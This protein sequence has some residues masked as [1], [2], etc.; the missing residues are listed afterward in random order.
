M[1]GK[2]QSISNDDWLAAFPLIK[3]IVPEHEIIKLEA[4]TIKDIKE[5][6]AGKKAAY[7]WSGGK[8]SIVL[9]ALCRKAGIHDCLLAV[10]NLEYPVF[11]DWLIA[12]QP[13][14]LEIINTGQDMEWLIAH[15][16]M[17]F[18]DAGKSDPDRRRKAA[19]LTN[20]WFAIVQH[21]AQ[22]K[23]FV[24]RNLDVLVI[25]RRKADGNFIGKGGNIYTNGK[26]VTR[27][28]PL[29]YW[30]HEQILAYIAYYSLAMPPIYSWP[31]GYKCG[32]HPWPARQWI[33]S[34][35]GEIGRAHV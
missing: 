20:K 24:E 19:A 28:S 1:L 5:K 31:N 34:I 27:F 30:K 9:G 10:C 3:N 23:Y 32:T 6:T 7:G 12:N 16:E 21:R 26:G 22:T 17:L 2:K 35:E 18:P 8:D 13:E 4:D 14:G 11:M 25:G 29:A 33:D 15:P